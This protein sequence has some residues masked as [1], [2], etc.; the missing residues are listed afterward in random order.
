MAIQLTFQDAE[1]SGKTVSID[2]HP[3]MSIQA[4]EK[5]D[6]AIINAPDG[7][8][9]VVLGDYRDVQLKI[10]AAAAQGHESGEAPRKNTSM[11]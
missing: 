5:P 3:Q 2:A 4:G 7:R 10:Q 8:R 1:N 6:T 11:S 9:F